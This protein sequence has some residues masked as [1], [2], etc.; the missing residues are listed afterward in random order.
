MI[1]ILFNLLSEQNIRFLRT[2]MMFWF[3]SVRLAGTETLGSEARLRPF[4]PL[5]LEI[6]R[7]ISTL[8]LIEREL[9]K[10]GCKQITRMS[11]LS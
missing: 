1:F 9:K 7:D 3:R 5:G 2:R 6:V 11:S 10:S 4:L 8:S